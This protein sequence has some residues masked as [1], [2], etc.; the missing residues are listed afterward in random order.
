MPSTQELPSRTAA[1]PPQAPAPPHTLEP[2]PTGRRGRLVGL[3]VGGLVAST[4]LMV[5]FI[6]YRWYPV[7]EPTTAVIV[8]GDATYDGAVVTVVGT[9]T[10]STRLNPAN[11]YVASILLKPGRYVVTVKHRD[12]VLIRQDVEI[13]RFLGVRFRLKE[14]APPSTGPATP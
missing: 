12:Q 7:Q 14:L 4:V 13:K 9:S 11:N 6:W 3:I 2:P 1:A 5:A 8:A 10:I